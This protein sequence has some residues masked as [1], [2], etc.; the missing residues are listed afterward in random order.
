M[1]LFLDEE[2][3]ML[4]GMVNKIAQTKVNAVFCQ[5]GID[6]TAQHYLAKLGILAARRVKKSDMEALSKATGAH[7]ISN[8]NDLAK[9]DL[10]SAGMVE[11]RKIAGDEMIFIEEC[12]QPKAV[13]ILLRGGT[14]HVID[15]VERA[16]EDA[17]KGI[18]S[19]LELGKIVPGGGASEIEV[20]RDLRKYAES[21][22]GREQ[23]AVNAFADA[24]E[25][26][27]RSLAENAG[28][29]PIDK[30]ANL[31]AQHDKDMASVGLDVFTGKIQDMTKL[32]VIEP[33]K[34]KLQAVQSAAEAA[35]M[36]LRIDDV[37]SAG[38]SERGGAPSMPPGGMP[39]G[40]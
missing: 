31:R 22:K 23:L 30:L 12:K 7:I 28:L 26:I 5:K 10:G 27:P 40:Y 33:L 39:P 20:A 6:D 2:E 15:E 16:M 13:T 21:F 38:T 17:I 25:V 24:I 36:I 32:G 35:E 29:D 4:K 18:A 8:I 3:R 34:I 1:Q 11:E 19:A 14:E 37:I 9:E